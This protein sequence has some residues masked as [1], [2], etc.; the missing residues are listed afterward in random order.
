MD[1]T[2]LLTWPSNDPFLPKLRQ[3]DGSFRNI[4]ESFF[5]TGLTVWPSFKSS[6]HQKLLTDRLETTFHNHKDAA[7][8]L[9]MSN[10]LVEL[11]KTEK[12]SDV[13]IPSDLLL[14]ALYVSS[15]QAVTLLCVVKN[16]ND[17][18]E[19]KQKYILQLTRKV[20]KRIR[21]FTD[22][23]V[24]CIYGLL[25]SDELVDDVTFIKGLLS[26]EKN[27]RAYNNLASLK[28]TREKCEKVFNAF[29]VAVGTIQLVPGEKEEE[30]LWLLTEEE[31][32]ERIKIIEGTHEQIEEFTEQVRLRHQMSRTLTAVNTDTLGNGDNKKP[33]L[34]PEEDRRKYCI[35]FEMV[36]ALQ[37][38]TSHHLH[39]LLELNNKTQACLSLMKAHISVETAPL[40]IVKVKTRDSAT[41]TDQPRKSRRKQIHD[42]QGSWRSKS[43]QCKRSRPPS[44]LQPRSE[45]CICIHVC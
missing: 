17:E 25:D 16:K 42:A 40:G 28:M 44:A 35:G 19:E 1:N 37:K 7:G 34:N 2:S 5:S 21:Q 4:R 29:I 20:T 27:A 43:A 33:R 36:K 26:M 39:H 11:L 45:G 23:H 15:S 10:S 31:F 18:V 8:L 9:Y 24:S 38:K 12:V 22:E 13:K 3:E 14:E 6:S 32:Y 41:Q 30:E